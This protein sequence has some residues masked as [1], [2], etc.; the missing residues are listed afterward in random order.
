MTTRRALL[1]SAAATG[2][3][4]AAPALAAPRPHERALSA[5]FDSLTDRYLGIYPEQATSVGVD[6]GARAGLKARLDARSTEGRAADH[7]LC[8]SGLKALSAIPDA[9]LSEASRTSKAVITYALELG[10]EGR[11]FDF[12]TNTL[13]AA[14]NE[15]QSPHVVDQQSGALADVPEMLDS[16]H[17]VET[18]ADAHAYVARVQALAA[19]LDAETDRIAGDAAK[20]VMP[21]NFLL[22]NAIGQQ[23]AFLAVQPGE[24]RLLQSLRAKL[25]AAGLSQAAADGCEATL[26]KAVYPAVTRQLAALEG[27]AA[28]ADDKA[29]VWRLKDGDAYYA[30]CLKVGTTTPMT[31]DAVHHL[32]LEQNKAIEARMDALLK[33]QGY[34][35]GT[36]G[37]RMT[38]L[39]NDPKNRF[40]DT[41][42]GRRQLVDY[43][44]ATIAATRKRMGEVSALPLKAPVIVR[45]VPTDIQD[46]AALGY[47]N[48]GTIDGSRPSIYYINL[49]TTANWPRFTL[50]DLTYHETLPGHAWQGAYLIETGK[51]PLIRTILSGFNAYVEGWALYSE[52]LADEI[53]LY[54]DD[55]LGQLRYLQGLKFRAVRL[56]VDTGLHAKRWTREQAIDW[57]VANSGRTRAAMTSEI[58]RYC[59]WPGQ[60]CG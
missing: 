29:G 17:R 24:A 12:G 49:K 21:P 10:R 50:P 22:S 31:P 28:R 20:G 26:T 57:A 14:M 46:G 51:L 2:A 35:Q 15:S 1:V 52:Q 48:T 16:Q 11:A 7:A 58:D 19:A 23:K 40:P 30:W 32:G 5:A 45:P 54:H 38:A 27:L 9:G 34:T 25:K 43:L 37:E 59:S 41:A 36:V 39:T 42:E 33:G 4:A 55:P 6:T 60:A 13:W 8:A 47:M 3:A 18:V 53:G 56:V 44:N